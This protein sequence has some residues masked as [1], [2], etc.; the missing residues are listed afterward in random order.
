MGDKLS[1]AKEQ[2]GPADAVVV[3]VL[4]INLLIIVTATQSIN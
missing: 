4:T 1:I 2:A 3:V